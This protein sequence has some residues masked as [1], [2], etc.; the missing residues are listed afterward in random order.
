MSQSLFNDEGGSYNQSSILTPQNTLDSSKLDSVGLPRYTTTYAISQMCYNFSL[1]AAIAHVLLWNWRELSRAFGKMRFMQSSQDIDDPH[2]QG[3]CRINGGAISA[4]AEMQRSAMKKYKEV[5]QWW[6]LLLLAGALVIG[7]GC[8]VRG[9]VYAAIS[10]PD[11]CTWCST[12]KATGYFPLGVSSCS[13]SLAASLR[14]ALVSVCL[15][16]ASVIML[17]IS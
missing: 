14:F 12:T 7:I 15:A 16:F 4:D 5:P 6:Y 2:Y 11:D 17:D 10:P 8:S 1:G 9:W 3:A 13:R